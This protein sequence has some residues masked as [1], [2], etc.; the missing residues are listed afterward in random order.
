MTRHD[1]SVP[2]GRWRLLRRAREEL[3]VVVDRDPSV[4]SRKEAL[5][6]PSIAALL[7]HRLGRAF[8]R[9]RMYHLARAVCVLTRVVTGGIE[10]H[11]G[12]RL[13]RR[14]FIDHGCG[15]VIGE[16]V[17]I[18]DDVTLFHQVTLGST[19]WWNDRERGLEARRHPKIGNGVTIGANASLL[20]P[21][22]IGDHAIVGAQTLVMHDVPSHAHVRAP[23]A[24]VVH[25][26]S[27]RP[28]VVAVPE[29]PGAL[30]RS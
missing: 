24:T 21:I 6:H 5:L 11:P 13:G 2:R 28:D 20:G 8:Y 14:F 26:E 18:G 15:V 10:I 3:D 4:H 17:I 19:G 30:A 23:L 27:A 12:A 25:P 7:G 16:T 29:H 22:T 9:R 1:L